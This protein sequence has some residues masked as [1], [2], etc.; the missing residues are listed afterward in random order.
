MT[1]T[2]VDRT[3]ASG[4]RT[5]SLSTAPLAEVVAFY[6]AR[7]TRTL[8]TTTFERRH[9]LPQGT[10]V[11]TISISDRRVGDVVIGDVAAQPGEITRIVHESWPE[12]HPVR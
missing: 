5:I 11:E 3:G 10:F 2:L 4:W 6:D 1:L 9:V 8:A 12:G 7:A